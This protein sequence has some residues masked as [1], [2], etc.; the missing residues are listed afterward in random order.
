METAQISW[1]NKQHMLNVALSGRFDSLTAPDV[2]KKIMSYIEGRNEVSCTVDVE[3]LGYISSAGLRVLLDLKKYCADLK[4]VNVSL[5]IY[6]ILT[7]TGFTKFITVERRIRKMREPAPGDILSKDKDSTLYRTTSDLA[8]RIF[9]PEISLPDVQHK[10][11]LSKTA[12]SHGISTPIAFEI[13]TCG[14]SYGIL[15][16]RTQG[17]TLAQIWQERPDAMQEEIKLLTEL[18]HMIHGCEIENNELPD[19][20]ERI[21]EELNNDTGLTDE[22]RQSLIQLVKRLPDTGA[23]LVGELRL[24][25]VIIRD[26]RLMIMDLTRCGRGNPILDLQAAVSAMFADGH[27]IF[28]KRF[29][30]RYTQKI[31]EDKRNLL[32]HVLNP[33]IKPWWQ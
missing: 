27:G 19:F 12:V 8:V 10:F 6:D 17:K 29:F 16:E 4:V 25:N 14:D 30:A 28:W 11:R 21:L 22:Q 33:A 24:S 9:D 7:M 23:F 26:G 32:E 13:V 2:E 3:K 31:S 1:D 5:D 15:Y 20:G 18:V